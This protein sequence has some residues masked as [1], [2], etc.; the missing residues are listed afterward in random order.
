MGTDVSRR[1]F[2][3]LTGLTVLTGCE[4]LRQQADAQ[5]AGQR[6]NIIYILLDD[7]GYGDFGCF[8]QKQFDTPNIDRLAQEGMRFTQHYAGSTVCA[9][10]RCALMTGLHTGRCYIRGNREIK[11][12]GQEPL[13]DYAVTVAQ[14]LGQAGYTTGAF[15]KWGLGNPGSV[16]EPNQQG[17]DEFFGYN[18]QR[19][20]HTYYPTH[21]W[22]NQTKVPL[23][24]KTY[25]HDLIT[26][27]AL[28]FIRSHAAKPFFC[29]MPVT[30]PHAALQV[31][32]AYV[33]PFREKFSQFEG[34]EG[35][36][37][38]TTIENPVAAFAG[39]MKKIDEDVGRVRDVVKELGIARNTLIIVTSDNGPHHEGGH[40]PEFFDSNGPWSGF[41]RDLTEGGIRVP[42]VAWWPGQV[43]SGSVTDHM[44]AFW[45]FLPTACEMAGVQ[46]RER[47]DG[48][49]FLPTLLGRSHEQKKHDY[50]YWEFHE[51]GGKRALRW[52]KW[53]AIQLKMHAPKPELIQLF[54]L[55]QDPI[56]AHSV[57][58]LQ[59][60]IMAQVRTMF[61]QAHSRSPFKAWQW[62]H[63]R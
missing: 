11:P 36:Y 30:I 56:E 25:A 19:Q 54:D 45:D 58:Q 10:S 9:P 23:D 34:Q 61:A 12:E 3:A 57:A 15:G 46:I 28:A 38:G 18:C 22:H 16:G 26:Y 60:E 52:G 33:A 51:Q 24:G 20:A 39:M 42:M 13:P 4:S 32:E 49:S 59:P 41:K 48:I 29:Y 2:L 50:L 1:H 53:K 14:L 21:L 27:R 47:V 7:A 63:E 31:P 43:I 40:N 37:A 8:G 44:S 55:E 5:G 17:F 35:R 6:P 62:P